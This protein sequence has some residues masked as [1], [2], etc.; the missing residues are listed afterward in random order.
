MSWQMLKVGCLGLPM[1][2]MPLLDSLQSNTQEFPEAH[3]LQ[4]FGVI[5]FPVGA[6][7]LNN[8]FDRSS[9]SD[10]RFLFPERLT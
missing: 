8:E 1:K 6:D 3:T 10:N 7:E 5:S 2:A 4:L 9:Q